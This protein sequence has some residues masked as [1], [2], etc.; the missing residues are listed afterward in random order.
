MSGDFSFRSVDL[1]AAEHEPLLLPVSNAPTAFIVDWAFDSLP[2][3]ERISSPAKQIGPLRFL[4]SLLKQRSAY[5]IRITFS[6][7][8]AS[9]P[10][11]YALRL[12]SPEF[13]TVG[14]ASIAQSS[15][16]ITHSVALIPGAPFRLTVMLSPIVSE[17]STEPAAVSQPTTDHVGLKNQ[18]ATC[19]LN[20]VIQALFHIPAFRALVF[21]MPTTGL[22]DA[23][24]S[25]PLTLQRLFWAMQ[26]SKTVCSTSELTVSFGWTTEHVMIQQDAQE[27]FCV[28]IANLEEKMQNSEPELAYELQGLFRGEV[29]TVIRCVNVDFSSERREFFYDLCLDVKGFGN[30]IEAFR[31]EVAEERLDGADQYSTE[32]FG[33]QDAIMSKQFVSFPD[34]LQV[35]LRRFEFRG[36]MVKV[37]D[38]FEFPPILDLTA[39]TPTADGKSNV[40]ELF[41]VL[42]HLGMVGGHYYAFI[43]TSKAPIWYKFNDEKVTVEEARTTIEG[44]YG[45]KAKAASAYLLIYIRQSEIDRI[46]AE[47]TDIP[48]H[49]RA[50]TAPE[51]AE[52]PVK[53]SLYDRNSLEQNTQ[54]GAYGL[55]EA[56]IL[57]EFEMTRST[58]GT[59]LYEQV[60]SRIGISNGAFRL[61]RLP[62]VLIPK[63]QQWTIASVRA[64]SLSIYVQPKPSNEKVL[65]FRNMRAVI[66]KFF[67]PSL[68]RPIKLVEVFTIDVHH[69]VSTLVPLVN[70]ALGFPSDFELLC[71][72]KN[73]DRIA[74]PID[75]AQSYHANFVNPG[76]TLV[77]QVPPG[78]EIPSSPLAVDDSPPE[79]VILPS[80]D[81]VVNAFDVIPELRTGTVEA[82][83]SE[84][85][86]IITTSV[87]D[88]DD[89]QDPLFKLSLPSSLATSALASILAKVLNDPDFDPAADSLLLYAYDEQGNKPAVRPI[90]LQQS[91][92]MNVNSRLYFQVIKNVTSEALLHLAPYRL[93]IALDG[94]TVTFESTIL[95]PPNSRVRDLLGFC[96]ERKGVKIVPDAFLKCGLVW[97]NALLKEI[98]ADEPIPSPAYPIRIDAIS[99]SRRTNP[100]IVVCQA[101]IDPFG[102]FLFRGN[103]VWAE[104][105]EA[106]TVINAVTRLRSLMVIPTDIIEYHLWDRLT[107]MGRKIPAEAILSEVT[108]PDDA[109]VLVLPAREQ[110][111][112]SRRPAIQGIKIFH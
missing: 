74:Q 15:R 37:T 54:R 94:Y 77:F 85:F 106:E 42:T 56:P 70:A 46:Y 92:R 64:P 7:F 65:L 80:E 93:L 107:R 78:R 111:G 19:Y 88:F 76:D 67:F 51:E 32:G 29:K 5:S 16:F 27:F 33:K 52:S 4:I 39:I 44:N 8:R 68:H 103:Y 28:L 12:E 9:F 55:K 73:H 69:L 10:C 59:D 66:V 48:D 75:L 98:G 89:Q 102:R 101:T 22:E 112:R 82:Y 6:G 41:A 3:S 60:A 38:R 13:Q 71:F 63:T 95:A 99:D 81:T 72:T 96:K 18:S 40:F 83:F 26:T 61:W 84:H 90:S 58:I 23:T 100:V 21:R 62:F 24:V 109:L 57:A 20:S 35:H 87:Y 50:Y 31:H 97:M 108:R 1:T 45:D 43:R 86:N 14:T 17:K 91:V 49:I 11:H 47:M 25:I 79:T 36:R 53:I 110:P 104:R 2:D 34:V 30:L 105:I